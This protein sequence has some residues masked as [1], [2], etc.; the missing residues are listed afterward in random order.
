RLSRREDREEEAEDEEESVGHGGTS[1][2]APVPSPFVERSTG[3]APSMTRTRRLRDERDTV[4][5]GNL[6]V[7]PSL[8]G[9][10]RGAFRRTRGAATPA[11]DRGAG[12]AVRPAS[13]FQHAG[14]VLDHHLVGACTDAHQP[15]IDERT[16]RGALAHVAEAAVE[17]DALVGDPARGPA[18]EELRHRDLDGRVLLAEALP[19]AG[20]DHLAVRG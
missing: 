19:E 15:R 4:T 8:C 14:E 20:V 11:A 16:P 10:Q 18:D 1:L 17:L 9:S 12:E 7:K 6:A 3:S 13:E 2:A 5:D